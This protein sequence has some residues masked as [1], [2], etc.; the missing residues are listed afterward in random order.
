MS[1]KPGGSARKRAKKVAFKRPDAAA[2]RA[3]L[4]EPAGGDFPAHLREDDGCFPGPDV[5]V[6]DDLDLD[7]DYPP[8]S[9]EEWRTEPARLAVTAKRRTLYVVRVGF[10]EE[11][12][13][14]AS[15]GAAASATAT[16]GP[17]HPSLA[18]IAAFVA[19]FYHGLPVKML[20]PLPVVPWTSPVPKGKGKGKSKATKHGAGA[21]GTSPAAGAA[22]SGGKRQRGASAAAS[23]AAACPRYVAVRTSTSEVRVRCRPALDGVFDR[24]LNLNDVLDALLEELPG[25]A[26]A[27][28][29]ITPHDL[30]EVDEEDVGDEDGDEMDVFTCGRA[31]GG[32]RIALISSARYSP[33]LDAEQ[34]IKAAACWPLGV[35]PPA[36][37]AA[38]AAAAA[39]APPRSPEELAG[40][41]LSRMART[42]THELGHCLGIDHCVYYAC[43]MQGS[44]SLVEDMKQPPYLCPVDLKKVLAASGTSAIARCTAL[45]AFC[46][47]PDC[48]NIAMFAAYAA[49][50]RER[51]RVLG[52]PA[53]AGG[54]AVGGAAT[55][56]ADAAAVA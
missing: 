50:L 7:P 56:G 49:W 29:G 9:F 34:G 2:R 16:A 13:A 22:V 30:Y 43:C 32:S 1:G 21:V 3:A 26:F 23:A 55:G 48:R 6:G 39:V 33:A 41:W 20:P 40:L 28:C 38:T 31:Y 25:D 24:Q 47:K 51:L 27:I 45:L 46:E 37:P 4:G 53:P 54:A 8:Q 5:E 52:V 44:A 15:A 18:S 12:S 35:R 19:A 42:V 11:A 17:P 10:E 14:A 36:L